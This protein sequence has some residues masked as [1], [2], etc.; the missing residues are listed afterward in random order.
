[1]ANGRSGI[2]GVAATGKAGN[3]S[4]KATGGASAEGKAGEIRGEVQLSGRSSITLKTDARLSAE[5]IREP[6]T[7]LELPSVLPATQSSIGASL[8]TRQTN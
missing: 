1:M 6:F 5:I 2:L 4:G 8:H 3:L 7:N